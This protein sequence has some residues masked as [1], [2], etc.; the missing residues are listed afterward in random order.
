MEEKRIEHLATETWSY[1]IK[2]V[3][4]KY[5]SRK[6]LLTLL[7]L[8]Y[9]CYLMHIDG[10]RLKEQSVIYFILGTM[11]LCCIYVF[12]SSKITASLKMGDKEIKLEDK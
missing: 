7:P 8:I 12:S 6:F 1:L 10:E 4:I 9:A 3:F 11:L 5:T 2:G